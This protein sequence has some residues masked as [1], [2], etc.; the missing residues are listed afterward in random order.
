MMDHH[1]LSENLANFVADNKNQISHQ[2]IRRLRQL[3][4]IQEPC[5]DLQQVHRSLVSIYDR[6]ILELIQAHHN[7]KQQ[8]RDVIRLVDKLGCSINEPELVS[9][10]I[11][12]LI[13]LYKAAGHCSDTSFERG[14]LVKYLMKEASIY[15]YKKRQVERVLQLIYR[16]SCF[17]INKCDDN[18][19]RLRLKARLKNH[20]DFRC[21]LDTEIISL[22]SSNGI[23]L[24]PDS[25]AY[26]LYR[27]SSPDIMAHLQS[28]LDRT[29]RR[30]TVEDLIEIIRKAGDR[31]GIGPY[32]A[33][34]S[35]ISESLNGTIND[36]CQDER[37]SIDFAFSKL[38]QLS[39]LLTI[40]QCRNTHMSRNPIAAQ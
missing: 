9:M 18:P 6:L 3:C 24:Q 30:V 38:I 17:D 15:G 32:M 33:D 5:K 11:E 8:E 7:T 35:R 2:M 26:L 29:K 27:R 10:V 4:E 34:L 23:L 16:C 13:K 36:S 21:Q 1:H 14:V 12:L 39:H 28:L 37:A 31:Y 40:R 19:S 20:N 22:A 25:W